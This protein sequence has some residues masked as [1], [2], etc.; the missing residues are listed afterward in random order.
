MTIK[1]SD[2][3]TSI[4][5]TGD[6]NGWIPKTVYE[7]NFLHFRVC[8]MQNP[9]IATAEA[10][11]WKEYLS[12]TRKAN[13]GRLMYHELYRYEFYEGR[14]RSGFWGNIENAIKM[15][16]LNESPK[17]TIFSAGVGRDLLKVGLASGIWQSSAP[18]RIK[19]THKEISPIYFSLA[20]PNARLM[21]TE[22]EE[23]MLEALDGTI[24]Q[25]KRNDL[26]NEEMITS[27]KWDFRHKTPLVNGTQDLVVFAL[28]GN[29]AT[30]E[31]QPSI[32]QEIARCITKGGYLI[33]AT[34]LPEL[35]FS[36]A[37]RGI[38]KLKIILSSPLMWPIL[39][40]FAPWQIQWGK[41]AGKMNELGYWKNVPAKKWIEF[42]KPAGMKLIKI[43]SAPSSLLPV[44][45]LVM[46]KE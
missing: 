45:V 4:E 9:K 24:L 43:Y 8:P 21:V 7:S 11:V 20:K 29:Y 6:K 44:E 36:K 15:I 37:H 31:E 22:Y 10:E 18:N 14:K 46:Q 28:T 2:A 1:N 26:L 25:L 40:E 30:I 23:H 27:R 13:Q 17:I 34:M 33:A 16:G 3:W 5:L 35:E 42:L 38:R 12:A 19:G 32:L 39:H 41:M